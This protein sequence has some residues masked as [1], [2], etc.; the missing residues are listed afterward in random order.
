MFVLQAEE[1][2][3]K[4]I[5]RKIRNKVGYGRIDHMLIVIVDL[6]E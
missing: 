2:E 5:R 3:L 4:K 6:W 1:R